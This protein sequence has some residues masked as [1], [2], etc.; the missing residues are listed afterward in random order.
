MKGVSPKDG[1]KDTRI[2]NALVDNLQDVRFVNFTNS[3]RRSLLSLLDKPFTLKLRMEILLS[4][5]KG[6]KAT[7][8][9]AKVFMGLCVKIACI[10]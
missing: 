6:R 8:A 9:G 10:K 2:S 3:L 5:R 1:G 4:I 7:S